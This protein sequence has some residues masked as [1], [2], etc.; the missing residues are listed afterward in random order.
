MPVPIADDT[1]RHDL[2]DRAV[3][4]RSRHDRIL[5]QMAAYD[6]RLVHCKEVEQCVPV[7]RIILKDMPQ[8]GCDRYDRHVG[9]NNL[10]SRVRAGELTPEERY[11][12]G[13][14]VAVDDNDLHI[15]DAG[16]VRGSGDGLI[17]FRCDERQDDAVERLR[18]AGTGDLVIPFDKDPRRDERR[19]PK[20]ISRFLRH[21][22]GERDVPGKPLLQVPHLQHSRHNRRHVLRLMQKL[23]NECAEII[24]GYL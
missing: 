4:R 20:G 15:A 22:R 23:R 13:S 6:K 21:L 10:E 24:L 1:R 3:G 9:R 12:V 7:G 16:G 11:Y 2:H 8:P 18:S 14:V 19:R 5:V 17:Q